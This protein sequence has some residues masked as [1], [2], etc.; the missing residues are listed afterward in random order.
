MAKGSRGPPKDFGA[1]IL[2]GPGVTLGKAI[3]DAL[4][5]GR[6][7][8]KPDD[9]LRFAVME[10]AT[11]GTVHTLRML[12]SN[13][14]AHGVYVDRLEITDPKGRSAA[15]TVIESPDTI[16]SPSMS[17]GGGHSTPLAVPF[18]LGSG[19]RALLEV[20]ASPSWSA[21][22]KA[23]RYG[24]IRVHFTVLGVAADDLKADV[25]FAVRP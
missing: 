16:L 3:Y 20:S 4:A 22:P 19:K 17:F 18:L 10:S 21:G 14:G 1:E 7:A 6:P 23:K 24:T 9:P 12:V 8:V 15:A 25:D 2:I 13:L 11:A 5:T